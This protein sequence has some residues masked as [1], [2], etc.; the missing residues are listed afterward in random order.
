M[1]MEDTKEFIHAPANTN[2]Q[3][4]F[5]NSNTYFGTFGLLGSCVEGFLNFVCTDVAYRM[6]LLRINFALSVV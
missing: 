4:V 1:K 2:K 5:V 3:F 6:A